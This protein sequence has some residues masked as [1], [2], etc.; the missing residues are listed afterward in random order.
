MTTDTGQ[1]LFLVLW[2]VVTCWILV[3]GI[4]DD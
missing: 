2:F 1:A 3:K 4:E